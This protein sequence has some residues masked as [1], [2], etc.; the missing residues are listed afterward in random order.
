M[1]RYFIEL[2]YNGSAFNGWQIQPNAP[3]VQESITQVLSTILRQ[4]IKIYG[5]GRTDTGV[6]AKHFYAHFE[7]DKLID[8]QKIK[9]TLNKM[10]PKQIVIHKIFIVS[11]D[12]HSRFSA[13]SRTY[14]YYITKN[15]D[16]FNYM[17]A[18][19]VFPFP[20]IKRMNEACNYLYEYTDFSS[21]SKSRTAT[22]TNNCNLM[23]AQWQEDG[24]QLV[25]TIKANR[26]LRNMVRAI[27]GTLIEI[28]QGK[29]EPEDIKE[30]I[31]AKDRGA[32]GMSVV[33]YALFLTNIEY[34]EGFD[35]Y[36]INK[37]ESPK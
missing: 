8:T 16:P 36:Y 3:S 30:I 13:L 27:V 5:A 18:Y 9:H 15:K 37:D 24:D 32:A 17:Y 6:H 23:F 2:S 22:K 31:E 10:L 35:E 26:F 19:R 14:K 33:G 25:F 4:E 34:P 20:D 29:L 12:M 28:G 11:P 21:F 1:N 7:V